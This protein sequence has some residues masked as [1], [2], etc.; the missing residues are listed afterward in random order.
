MHFRGSNPRLSV[1]PSS[2]EMLKTTTATS[3]STT[4]CH[5]HHYHNHPHLTSATPV[6]SSQPPLPPAP[7]PRRRRRC[8][9]RLL[10]LPPAVHGSVLEHGMH[11]SCCESFTSLAVRQTR[12]VFVVCRRRRR[13]RRRDV[14]ARD[15]DNDRRVPPRKVRSFLQ[16]STLTH[17]ACVWETGS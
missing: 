6:A 15:R 13:R 14:W 2:L 4:I 17:A 11:V 3:T 7:P 16:G 10:R 1:S 8:R 12:S 5:H 9:Q